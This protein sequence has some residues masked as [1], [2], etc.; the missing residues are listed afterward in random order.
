V[1]II[2]LWLVAAAGQLCLVAAAVAGLELA[3]D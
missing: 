2:W 3:L 1:L